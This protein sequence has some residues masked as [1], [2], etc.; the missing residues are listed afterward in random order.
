MKSVLEIESN[1]IIEAQNRLSKEVCDDLAHLFEDL[2]STGNSL[3]F[4]GV[5]KSGLVGQKLAATFSSLGL[6]SFFL[7]PTEALHGDLGSVR[8]G[9]GI[10]LISYSGTSEEILKLIPFLPIQKEKRIALVGN[11]ESQIA[12]KCKMILNCHVE[13]EACLHNQAPTTSSTL[14]MAL[15]DAMAVLY[16]RIKGLSKEDFAQNHPGGKLGKSLRLKVS[17]LMI[18]RDECAVLAKEDTLK[19]AILK[20]TEYPLGA[21]VI[22]DK[23]W[24]FSGLIVEADIRRS[25]G[26]DDFDVNAKA[27]QI[28]NKNPIV[29]DSQSLARE[30]LSLMENRSRPFSVLPVVDGGEFKGILRLHDLFKEGLSS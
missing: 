13:K 22:V 14:T 10:V 28:A 18:S 19:T 16:E 8:K 23:D 21:A 1:A 24:A 25:L 2:L 20:M 9:D 29:I 27:F 30:A 17:D 3:I 12:L 4:C 5:G 11:P 26:Q 15:G 7:H 6:P